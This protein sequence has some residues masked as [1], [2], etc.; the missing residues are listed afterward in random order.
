MKAR[1]FALI[2]LGLIL[3]GASAHADYNDDLAAQIER[4]R[5]QMQQQRN[6]AYDASRIQLY[7]GG[8]YSP[9]TGQNCR[10]VRA[11]DGTTRV[12]CI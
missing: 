11:Y 9:S 12:V 8:G 10:Y 7:Q 5:I 6:D 3:I 2:T 1:A 4:T